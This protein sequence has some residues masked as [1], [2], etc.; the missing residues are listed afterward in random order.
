MPPARD[1]APLLDVVDT[2]RRQGRLGVA[3]RPL[4]EIVLAVDETELKPLPLFQS[5]GTD[6]LR[7]AA[8]VSDEVE[9]REGTELLKEGRF[10]YEF[11]VI[12]DGQAEVTRAGQHVADLG[13]G[14]FLGEIAALE[15][16]KRTASVTAKSSMSLIVM[17]ARDLR[18]L[19]DSMPELGQKLRAAA[20]E[21]HPLA[22]AG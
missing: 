11:M 19:A 18:V 8:Q 4:L 20:A 3:V 5:L 7:R 17:T 13:P 2:V 14:D 15:S 1:I 22:Q 6:E 12:Q 10:A 21:R 16:G 9:V